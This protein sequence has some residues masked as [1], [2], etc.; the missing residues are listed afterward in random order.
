MCKPLRLLEKDVVTHQTAKRGGGEKLTQKQD[1]TKLWVGWGEA[2]RS[3]QQRIKGVG[4]GGLGGG[5]TKH[6]PQT[7]PVLGTNPQ[8]ER[9]QGGMMRKRKKQNRRKTLNRVNIC[10]GGGGYKKKKRQ[11]PDKKKKKSSGLV[12]KRGKR[13]NLVAGENQKNRLND[14]PTTGKGRGGVEQVTKLV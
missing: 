4:G 11:A 13:H 9:R 6:T 3:S 8:N 12:G 5:V 14:P 7:T 10:G 1:R 2:N